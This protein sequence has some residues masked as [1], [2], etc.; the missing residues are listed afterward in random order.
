MP[1]AGE[2]QRFVSRGRLQKGVQKG[3]CP[4]SGFRQGR[5]FPSGLDGKC[6]VAAALVGDVP[7]RAE[8]Q[9]AS[10][11][12]DDLRAVVGVAVFRVGVE[13]QA[14]Q[15]EAF[16][17]IR[18]LRREGGQF[19]RLVQKQGAVVQ[20]PGVGLVLRQ[21][22]GEYGVAQLILSRHLLQIFQGDSGGAAQI[23][24]AAVPEEQRHRVSLTG[25]S[26]A[27]GGGAVGPAGP[28]H[29][30]QNGQGQG[31][32]KIEIDGGAFQRLEE[33]LPPAGGKGAG[34][35]QHLPQQ[36]A[37]RLVLADGGGD[38]AVAAVGSGDR[39]PHRSGNR[40]LLDGGGRGPV[41]G[42]AQKQSAEAFPGAQGIELGLGEKEH[43]GDGQHRN[44]DILDKIPAPPVLVGHPAPPIVWYGCQDCAA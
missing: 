32:E 9:G 23:A 40:M 6:A 42:I 25:Y 14:R 27:A 17:V 36:S 8:T 5:L 28:G 38:A 18:R 2:I 31:G 29:V 21:V 13:A 39:Q 20:P 7:V 30:R 34:G 4:G 19:R 11:F 26:Q 15:Q 35:A 33:V 24:V 3:A 22:H 10:A 37:Q 12:T 16:V 43:G 41:L 44:N 1:R